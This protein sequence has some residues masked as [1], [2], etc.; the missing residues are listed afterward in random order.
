M[1]ATAKPKKKPELVEKIR[2]QMATRARAQKLYERADALLNEIAREMK[3]GDEVE[4]EGESGARKFRID[5]IEQ[6]QTL[7]VAEPV[8]A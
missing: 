4:L 2:K 5:S 6:A 1:S 8:T 3:P 7:S